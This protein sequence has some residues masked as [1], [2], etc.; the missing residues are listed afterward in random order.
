ME[1]L[2]ETLKKFD[3]DTIKDK[4]IT[5]S[6]ILHQ[7][8]ERLGISVTEYLVADIIYHFG[9]LTK[10]REMGGWCYA[11]KQHLASCLGFNKKTIERAINVLDKKGLIEKNPET[12]HLRTTGKWYNEVI[13]YRVKLSRK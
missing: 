6:L 7:Q 9:G 4:K 11:S 2:N 13:I 8:R 5:Y 1:S 12:K 10:S 3:V